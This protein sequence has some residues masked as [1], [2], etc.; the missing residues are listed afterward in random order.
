MRGVNVKYFILLLPLFF[1]QANNEVAVPAWGEMHI[2][3]PA[4]TTTTSG[5]PV[6]SLGTTTLGDAIQFDMPANNRLR[7]TGAKTSVFACQVNVALSSDANNLLASI[8]LS[9]T[10]TADLTSEVD[11]EIATAMDHGAMS[12]GF[13]VE[14]AQN[15][16]VELWL[17]SE[18]GNPD[19]I[20]DHMTLFCTKLN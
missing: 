18:S 11:R 12:T 1:L 14:L 8:Y 19:F 15:E 3:T 20:V 9:D 13:L 5:T 10:D 2:S 6:K 4:S 16:Y 17:D 7:Y